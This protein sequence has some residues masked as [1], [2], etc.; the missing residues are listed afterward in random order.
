VS[1]LGETLRETA[2]TVAKQ[3]ADMQTAFTEER[4]ANAALIRAALVMAE[5]A[6]EAI[7]SKLPGFVSALYLA[8]AGPGAIEGASER[9]L[10]AALLPASTLGYGLF[11]AIYAGGHVTGKGRVLDA[12][13]VVSIARIDVEDAASRYRGEDVAKALLDACSRQLGGNALRRSE[14]ARR[15]VSVLRS[16]ATL[17]EALGASRG[18]A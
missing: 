11:E 5:P 1:A 10:Y 18:R 15:R 3:H 9:R 12:R 4:G 14:E 17:I 6:M 16:I 7:C 13:E 8:S 2:L